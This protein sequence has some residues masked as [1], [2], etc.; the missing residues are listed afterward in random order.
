MAIITLGPT[1]TGIRGS[2]GGSTFSANKAGPY[3]KAK[4][5][6]PNPSTTKQSET[7]GRFITPGPAWAAL[8]SGQRDGWNALTAAPPEIV[9]NSL[10][11]T[12]ALS[13][14]QWFTKIRLRQLAI[15]DA[16]SDDAPAGSAPAQAAYLNANF[17]IDTGFNLGYPAGYFPANSWLVLFTAVRLSNTPIQSFSQRKLTYVDSSPPSSELTV[18]TTFPTVWGS[19]KA[20]M[21]FT[22]SFYKQL[23]NGL[24]SPVLTRVSKPF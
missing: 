3:I 16:L 5:R 23:E 19:I 21:I 7:R 15:G 12:I 17:Y 10:G 4:A 13:G 14:F 8:T 24:R 20:N 22:S 11:E 1:I 2:I 9:T 18:Y 6:G